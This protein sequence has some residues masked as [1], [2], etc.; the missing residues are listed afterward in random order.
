[1]WKEDFSF[2]LNNEALCYLDCAATT[3]APD[4]VL[5]AWLHY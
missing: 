1:M 5:E 3:P 4:E 2:L